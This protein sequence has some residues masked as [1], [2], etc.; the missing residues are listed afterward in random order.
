M[1]PSS[2][3]NPCALDASGFHITC[4]VI[5]DPVFDFKQF[6]VSQI[7]FVGQHVKIRYPITREISA[8]NVSNSYT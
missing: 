1:S 8:M 2:L 3:Q 7:M 5:T 6:V 4:M